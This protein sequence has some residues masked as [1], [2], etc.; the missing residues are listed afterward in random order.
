MASHPI[1]ASL[2]ADLHR[3][4]LAL[5]RFGLGPRPGDLARAAPDPRADLA[6]EIEAR[7]VP[8]PRG[9]DLAD[10][11]EVLTAL[12]DE[13]EQR[14][15]AATAPAGAAQDE[16]K[17]AMAG[18]PLPQRLYRA[19]AMARLTGAI[20]D[21][22]GFAERLVWFWANHFAVSARKGGPVRATAGCF[23]REAIRPHVLGRFGDMLLAA[24]THPA[25]LFYLDNGQSIGPNSQAGQ[26]R[27]RGLN[28]NLAREILE[29]HTL[30]VGGGYTQEDV[31]S[32]ARI[33]TGWTVAGREGR[34]G[35]PGTYVYNGNWHEPG[36]HVLLGRA[37]PDHGPDQGRAALLDLARHS[38]TARHIARK[39]A[40]HFVAD[41]PPAPLV[42]RL[43]SVFR[44]TDGD[45][46]AVSLALLDAPEAWTLERAK[47]RSPQEFL[48]AAFRLLG[49][50]PAEPNAFLGG[51][52]AL[53]QPLWAPGG[54]DGYPDTVAQWASPEGLKT[55]MDVAARLAAQSGET[56][57]SALVDEALGPLASKETRKAVKR[58]ESRQQ[59]V[60]LLLMSPEFQR[61]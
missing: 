47:V 39:L 14:R 40:R 33:L 45:L 15:L 22:G 50:R 61:R 13:Q 38:S 21:E 12:R 8:R 59:A 28:E 55:R 58:A 30:G 18:P 44:D 53:G 46:A 42:D 25:M 36:A 10:T 16:A 54:P 17:P 60:A 57:P 9:P 51:L 56:D 52:A 6:G 5:S 31:T 24:E 37:Y 48:V 7:L 23:E 4:A 1:E 41:E 19:E 27:G 2:S 11:A 34:L 43:A 26:R 20:T 49:L 32:F 35:A 29:L 3:A